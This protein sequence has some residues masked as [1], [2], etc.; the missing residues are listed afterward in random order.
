M[1]PR[2]DNSQQ[3]YIANKSKRNS[4]APL[5]STKKPPV[6]QS[7]RLIESS[8]NIHHVEKNVQ[9]ALRLLYDISISSSTQN[10]RVILV[11]QLTQ[12]LDLNQSQQYHDI[13]GL[14]EDLPIPNQEENPPADSTEDG[15][16][17]NDETA[18]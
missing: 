10:E 5:K 2:S 4:T 11:A 17:S 14:K 7:Q 6:R 15:N 3:Q 16:N 12:Q 1:K 8:R 9:E 13:L 18:L